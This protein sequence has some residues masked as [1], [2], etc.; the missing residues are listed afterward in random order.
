MLDV[1]KQEKI[2][3]K[4]THTTI[5]KKGQ[6]QPSWEQLQPSL[7]VSDYSEHKPKLVRGHDTY[8]IKHSS[9][10]ISLEF[11]PDFGSMCDYMFSQS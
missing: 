8:T 2:Q 10:K 1:V 11:L 6:N 4:D 7:L 9:I 5:C 3:A